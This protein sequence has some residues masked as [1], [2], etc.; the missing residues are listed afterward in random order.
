MIAN[1]WF[2]WALLSAVFAALTAIFAQLGLQGV[3]ADLAT[4]IR[5]LIIV[6]VLSIFVV[7]TGKWANP[8][9]F[10][11]NTWI[12]LTLSGLAV[13]ICVTVVMSVIF[14]FGVRQGAHR[15]FEL[16]AATLESVTDFLESQG[17]LWGTR[18]APV[19]R[20]EVAGWQAVDALTAYHLVDP[21]APLIELE[22]QFDEYVFTLILSYRGVL[23]PL[24]DSPPGADALIES[25]AAEL[26]MA[27]YLVTR[28]A[29]KAQA[30]RSDSG[31][32]VL[33]L[34]FEN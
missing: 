34:T 32:C 26:L 31:V 27:G 33:R 16:N 24:P 17:R 10:P 30:S 23:L 21:A 28:S 18:H 8:F 3:D 1:D 6:A 14:R 12:F 11:A 2:H 13:G 7:A 4:L 19:R 29:R 5:T 9:A 15:Q 22:T 20:A 25:K